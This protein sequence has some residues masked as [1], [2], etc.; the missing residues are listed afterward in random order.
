MAQLININTTEHLHWTSKKSLLTG[1][2]PFAKRARQ[3][4]LKYY[5]TEDLAQLSTY[6]LDKLTTWVTGYNPDKGKNSSRKAEMA[7]RKNKKYTKAHRHT[8][9]KFIGT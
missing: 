7:L 9:D 3:L 6:R 4:A 1:N 2:S 8:K 5:K